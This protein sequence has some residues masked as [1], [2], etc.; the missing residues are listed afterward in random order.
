MEPARGN[1][2][3]LTPKPKTVERLISCGPGKLLHLSFPDLSPSAIR[4][5]GIIGLACHETHKK[6][7]KDHHHQRVVIKLYHRFLIFSFERRRY[8]ATVAMQ[9]I[10]KGTRNQ[11]LRKAQRPTMHPSAKKMD[12][13]KTVKTAK[14]LI[15]R[16][17]AVMEL[18]FVDREP[19]IIVK[20]DTSFLEGENRLLAGK[21][22]ALEYPPKCAVR[23]VIK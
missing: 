4:A 8:E 1:V 14:N 17:L 12:I 10:A 6:G 2:G 19:R 22:I 13:Q 16:I 5:P 7:K 11:R 9:K 3:P 18:V 15:V 20:S 21:G 23:N